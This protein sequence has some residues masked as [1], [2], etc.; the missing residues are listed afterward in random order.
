MLGT[1]NGLFRFR[2]DELVLVFLAGSPTV[3]NR[4]FQYDKIPQENERENRI[5]LSPISVCSI[6]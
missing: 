6:R 3:T 1:N 2:S 4:V 5:N